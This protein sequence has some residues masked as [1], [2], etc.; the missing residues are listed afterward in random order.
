M[1]QYQSCQV[2]R[3]TPRGRAAVAS[4]LL[5]GGDALAVLRPCLALT[6]SSLRAY[7]EWVW[8]HRGNPVATNGSGEAPDQ[9]AS[10]S[11]SDVP[12]F[13]DFQLADVREG[14]VIH[15]RRPDW[16]ELHCH[17]GDAVV[18]AME[19]ILVER[20]AV[21]RTWQ[22]WLLETREPELFLHHAP[23]D[24]VQREALQIL[25]LAETEWTAK[26]LLAQYHGALSRRI[27]Q[28]G[29]LFGNAA[30]AV[31]SVRAVR[32]ATD[33][34][35][36]LLASYE[37]GRHLTTPF[38][39]GLIGPVNVGKSCLMNALVGYNRSI[40][41][42]IAG[43]TRDTVS[44]KT[45]MAGWPVMLIDTAGIR[46]TSNPIEQEGI[47][48]MQKVMAD[49][50]LLLLITDV[51][52]HQTCHCPQ[53]IDIPQ[54]TPMIR[55]VNKIDLV[56]PQAL[57]HFRH[58]PDCVPVS[59]LTGAGLDQLTHAIMAKLLKSGSLISDDTSPSHTALVFTERQYTRLLSVREMP[60]RDE[61]A[62][63]VSSIL[64]QEQPGASVTGQV[65]K[66]R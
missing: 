59:A 48:R 10:W 9:F 44:A 50:D 51:R 60:G 29:N 34:L 58:L 7:P 28:L 30:T 49:S 8:S 23:L 2:V 43:T 11:K 16:I 65:M 52:E 26:L 21:S 15:F 19:A 27:K 39:V 40:T 33:I 1:T 46:E 63:A 64:N 54:T 66:G 13:A 57:L 18:N 31:L 22:D 45:V 20:G 62:S 47:S 56:D 53:I 38:R 55:V 6:Q 25:P 17:G 12:V 3:V 5:V 14:V 24:A 4:V 32:E 42:P 61:M 36:S 41:S 35:E 37:S